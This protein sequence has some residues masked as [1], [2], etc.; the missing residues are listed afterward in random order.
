MA[1]VSDLKTL[2][3]LVKPTRGQDHKSRLESFY[4]GQAEGYDEFRK[5]LLPGRQ[6]LID[7]LEIQPESSFAD[8]GCGTGI[9]LE[10]LGD[11]AKDLKK[12]YLVDLSPSLLAVA[13]KRVKTLGLSNVE[14]IES[15][16]SKLEL[17]EQ[18]DYVTFS[19]SLSMI[20]DWFS[21]ISSAKK[22]LKPSGKFGVVDFYVSRKF[23][24]PGLAQHGWMKR[25]L[26]P[27]WFNFDG[28]Y[29]NPDHLPFLLSQ[30]E[31][32]LLSERETKIPYLPLS[33][34]PYYTFIGKPR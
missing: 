10:L 5:R 4:G 20:P 25:T 27:I 28:V 24:G 23:S 16:V 29:P 22:W 12:I 8:F 31:T 14:I 11:R 13:Q 33:Q 3:H 2:L 30:F 21:A 1:L 18:L 26:W 6:E 19:Y 9:T 17:S 32:E 15:D 7:Q 34:M